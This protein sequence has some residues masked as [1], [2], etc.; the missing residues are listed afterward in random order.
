MNDKIN[1]SGDCDKLYQPLINDKKKTQTKCF[2]DNCG[3]Q[4]KSNVMVCDRCFKGKITLL[5]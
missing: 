1:I 2:C 5:S 3:K 4:F